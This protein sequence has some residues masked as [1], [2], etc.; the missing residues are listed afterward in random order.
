[1]R[2]YNELPI[3]MVLKLD[4]F[5]LLSLYARICIYLIFF[6]RKSRKEIGVN[7]LMF[8]LLLRSFDLTYIS[9]NV[10]KE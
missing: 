7:K 4:V 1:M 3:T 6:A 8:F 9:N 5:H 10:E 2:H